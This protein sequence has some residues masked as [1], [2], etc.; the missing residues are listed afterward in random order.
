VA[1]DQAAHRRPVLRVLIVEDQLLDA[2][3][4]LM[5]LDRLGYEVTWERVETREAMTAALSG[6][7][8]DLVISDFSLPTFDAPAALS[9]CQARGIDIPFIIVSGTVEEEHAVEAMRQGAQ[10]FM[11]KGRLA[12]LGPA[13]T[14]GLREFE[15]R[16]ARRMA[17]T[18]LA[19]AQKME[20]LG[21]LAGGVAHDFNNLLGV[22][23]GYSELLVKGLSPED[24]RA[25]RLGEVL[26]ATERGAALTRQLLAFSR[27]QPFEVRP[28]DL[29]VVVA[30]IEA[31][32]RRLISENVEIVTIL[33]GGLRRVKAD[34]NKLEQ[35]LMN[36]SINARD[37]MSAG[38]R[39]VIETSN[40]EFDERYVLAHP[41]AHVGPHVM[42]AV[43]DTGH[44]MDAATLSHAF[45]PFFTTKELGKGT[46]LGLATVYGIVRQSGGHIAA[47]SEPGRG[48]SFKIYLPATDEITRPAPA[49]VVAP[50]ERAGTETVLLVEDDAALRVL[51]HDLLE[52]GGYEVVGGPSPEAALAAAEQHSGKIDLI[53]TDVIM[54]SMSGMQA[55]SRMQAARPQLKVLFMS[56]HIR[57]SVEHQGGILNHHA[58]IQKPFGLDLLLR[59][60]REVLDAPS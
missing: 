40:V 33:H 11:N 37:A 41:D 57:A 2:E 13:I 6:R 19:Q 56:G 14:R 8:W 50:V 29:N 35:L 1:E 18:R 16:R 46:G 4:L 44:G 59:R 9:V 60:V 47:Y 26:R 38:G 32:L 49:P 10:D 21:Q 12:R 39:L 20:A 43:S 36:L 22:I 15:E 30:G 28:L 48:T 27:Q 55:V 51:I 34:A 52:Q 3:L 24:P 53:L 7:E 17:E 23:Q 45:E 31:M 58:F 42:L 5:E 54:P 25:R